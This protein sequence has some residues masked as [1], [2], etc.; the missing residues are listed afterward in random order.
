[1]NIRFACPCCDQPAR[2]DAP[3]PT[4]WQCPHCEHRVQLNEVGDLSAC[5]L[6]G[7]QELYKKKDFP[8][9]LG[10]SILTVAC[11]AFLL[12]NAFR[13]QW[14]AWAILLGS[15]LFDGLLYLWVGD[16]TVCY[17]C[18]A[19][20]RGVPSARQKPYDLGIAERYRQERIRLEQLDAER[21]K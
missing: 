7:N 4:A 10:M 3:L 14:L 9:W 6:C 13:L 5:A 2:L 20:F 8:H 17:R 16:V 15:A 19:H 1:V 21:K 12:L 18:A 11:A